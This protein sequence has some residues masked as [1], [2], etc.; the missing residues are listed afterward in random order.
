MFKG[1]DYR[2]QIYNSKSGI[3]IGQSIGKKNDL[4]RMLKSQDWHRSHGNWTKGNYIAYMVPKRYGRAYMHYM[5]VAG[6]EYE[7]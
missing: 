6:T 2:L 4:I 5:F 1:E 7:Y 3:S